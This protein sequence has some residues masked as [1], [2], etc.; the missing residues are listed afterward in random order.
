MLRWRCPPDDSPSFPAAQSQHGRK[1]T[2]SPSAP[3]PQVLAI[4]LGPSEDHGVFNVNISDLA[5][6][7][8]RKVCI[9][10]LVLSWASIRHNLCGKGSDELVRHVVPLSEGLVGQE[11]TD[12]LGLAH[13]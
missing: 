9:F 6:S 3:L 4:L 2:A 12:A 7:G 13:F 1:D 11:L 10:S 5:Q 8:A